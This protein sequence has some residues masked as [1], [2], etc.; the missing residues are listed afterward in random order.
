[1]LSLRSHSLITGAIFAALLAIGWG[2]N[3]LDGLGLLP[4]DR[5]LQIAVLALMLGL[6]VALA[7]SAVPLMVLIV[8]GFQVRIG[9]SGVPVIWT[10]IAHQ[11]TIVFVLWGLMAAGLLIAIPAAILGGAFEAIEFQR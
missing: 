11:R 5:A 6:C 8:L 10:L 2:G 4:H 7:F 1:M 3:L 9:N